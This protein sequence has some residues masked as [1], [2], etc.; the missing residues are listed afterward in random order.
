MPLVAVLGVTSFGVGLL[1]P[2]SGTWGSLPP[3]LAVFVLLALKCNGSCISAVLLAI[4]VISSLACLVWGG[5]SEVGFA[6]KDPSSVVADETAG[7]A[8]VLLCVP[9]YSLGGRPIFGGL[10]SEAVIWGVVA[11]VLFRIFDVIKPQP[12]RWLQDLRGGTGILLD[13]IAAAAY[14]AGCLQITLILLR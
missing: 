9:W 2:A 7:Q 4:A 5:A 10:G 13:D 12:A 14:A 8:L 1:R 11:F 6:G 3:L